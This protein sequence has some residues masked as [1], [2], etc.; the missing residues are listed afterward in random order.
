MKV[1]LNVMECSVEQA[2]TNTSNRLGM[3]KGRYY[4]GYD[5]EAEEKDKWNKF[6]L[7]KCIEGEDVN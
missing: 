4:D 1:F 3:L 5:V 6:T 7:K 2:K